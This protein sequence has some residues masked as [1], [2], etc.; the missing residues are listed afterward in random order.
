MLGKSSGRVGSDS[1]YCEN[2]CSDGKQPRICEGDLISPVSTPLPETTPS[3]MGNSAP[4]DD[5]PLSPN[6]SRMTASSCQ[7]LRHAVAALN[8]LDDFTCEKIGSGF[9]SEVFKVTHRSTGQ[10][11]V[12]KMNLLRSN[13]PNMLKEVQLMNK[14]SHPNILRFMGV[15]V[16]EG[17][18][19]ALTEYINGGS[20]E[21][22]IQNR[23]LELPHTIRIALA[24]DI[25]RGLEYL[26]GRGVFHRDLTSKNV[27]IRKGDKGPLDLTA[28]VGDFGL[29][30]KIPDPV[31]G[32]RLPTVG[33]FYWMSPECLKGQWYNE[34]SDVF[35]YG[36]VLCELI[37][38]I[39]ADPDFL[40]R[41]EN[42]G[43]DYLAFSDMVGSCPPEFLKLAF[44]C[45]TFEPKSRPSFAEIV[46][47]L[48]RIL[49]DYETSLNSP[50]DR[51]EGAPSSLPVEARAVGSLG[52]G[53]RSEEVIPAVVTGISSANDPT[54]R[55]KLSHRRSLSEDVIPPHTAPSDKARCHQMLMSPQ[56]VGETWSRKDPHYKPLPVPRA[57]PFAAL[58]QLRGVRKIITGADLFSSCVELPNPPP[59]PTC[60]SSE[61]GHPPARSLPASP[62]LPRKSPLSSPKS[63]TSVPTD[64]MFP[65]CSSSLGLPDML[66]PINGGSQVCVATV[67]NSAGSKHDTGERLATPDSSGIAC[68]TT[69]NCLPS[70]NISEGPENN[71]PFT[72]SSPIY[73]DESRMTPLHCYP[74]MNKC[75]SHMGDCCGFDNFMSSS[76]TLLPEDDVK[77]L[78]DEV[79]Q[80]PEESGALSTISGA[81]GAN[82]IPRGCTSSLNLPSELDGNRTCALATPS[83]NNNSCLFARGYASSLNLFAEEP[84]PNIPDSTRLRRRGSCESG[85]FSSAGEDLVV[86]GNPHT[87]ATAS[88]SA[89]LSSSSAA[90]SLFLLDDSSSTE[91]QPFRHPSLLFSA[92]KRA[93]SV[94][95][96]SSEDVSSL[97]G[98]DRGH[99]SKIVEYFE[100]RGRGIEDMWDAPDR[101]QR[102]MMFL[103]SR[104][105]PVD[106]ARRMEG[107]SLNDAIVRSSK[108]AALRTSLERMTTNANSLGHSGVSPQSTP[109]VGT[110]RSTTATQRLMICEG[111]VKSKLPLF[112][113]K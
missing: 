58:A 74:C 87:T 112:D 106:F 34:K 29:A 94:Y 86:P 33:S 8:R 95:T 9:F 44:H 83:V 67:N 61:S 32:Y 110:R 47:R 11:M 23:S 90:S 20:L 109:V 93:S 100:R 71:A 30:A 77:C 17:Q 60:T 48:E 75:S 36:I 42:F 65:C 39:E 24:R 50:Q 78:S 98:E 66:T 7:A 79:R 40:P 102:D 16:H 18:L 27:L 45:C 3:A 72:H 97:G 89:T 111:A 52:P 22:L 57:N 81:V 59:T 91:E 54:H 37:A 6:K 14:L 19:H 76:P 41:T 38:R 92:S 1:G 107:A 68:A 113:K 104:G 84:D 13:R 51:D 73:I 55:R 82:L 80:L 12:L 53:A 105:S 99:I 56:T 21:Q 4:E 28:V 88:S 64:L 43:L 108:M 15:C 5:N 35:S 70:V 31:S 103:G 26:H 46:P 96:D 62:T 25:A 69:Q 101:H 10:V 2:Q 85:F 49:S 63:K